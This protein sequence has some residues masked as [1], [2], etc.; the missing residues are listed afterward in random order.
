MKNISISNVG[1]IKEA[2][3]NLGDLTILIGGQASGKS[4]ALQLLK[5]VVD[6]THIVQTLDRYGF[7][8]SKSADNILRAY[9]GEG[10]AEVWNE[11][12]RITADGREY[13]KDF[14]LGGVRNSAE[15]LFYVPAQRILSVADGRP[16]YF[17]EFDNSTPYVLRHF[18]EMLR[19][20]LQG[21]LGDNNV[22]FPIGARLKGGVK[23]AFDH[24][25][26]H[27]GSV[28]MDESS[29]TKRMRMRVGDMDLPFMTWSAGQKEFMPLLMAFYC[30]SGPPQPIVNGKQ[31]EYVVIE[32]PEMGL[33]P[34]AIMAILLQTLELLSKG[35]KVIIST[36]SQ[37]LL[38]FAW[39]FSALTQY[40]SEI[41]SNALC[42]LFD[43]A[44]GA[45]REM[46]SQIADK[47]VTTYYFA[48]KADGVHSVDISTLDAGSDNVDIS[49]WG[50]LSRFAGRSVDVISKYAAQ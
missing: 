45:M 7:V 10:M 39:A 5:L 34:E 9:L 6:K 18:S 42:E 33:H 11:Q 37:V 15:K 40:T 36:H 41:R 25:I 32:E 31:Y 12:T 16:K 21:G 1:P 49:E 24:S 19:L 50:G 44:G 28:V 23:Y 47:K 48:R 17:T 30:L 29:G 13:P 3:L 35:K 38:E 43:I 20:F 2:T 14:L 8:V 46:L 22:L 26:F 27:G 4:L